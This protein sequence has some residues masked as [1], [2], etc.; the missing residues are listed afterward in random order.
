MSVL[1]SDRVCGDIVGRQRHD[2]LLYCAIV[3]TNNTVYVSTAVRAV[4]HCMCVRSSFISRPSTLP[5]Q[6][7][8]GTHL[9]SVPAVDK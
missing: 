4:R 6:T 9:L 7:L 5:K 3:L 1:V 8:H 2:L